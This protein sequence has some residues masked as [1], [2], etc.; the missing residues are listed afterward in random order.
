VGRYRNDQ[1]GNI[2][3]TVQQNTLGLK[4]GN[5]ETV[6]T[7][8]TQPDTVRVEIFPGQGEVIKFG[9]NADGQI[10]SLSYAGMKFVRV[11]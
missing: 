7:P 2:E 8:F 6:S 1:L 11:K 9:F 4:L 5:I 10:N 3:I